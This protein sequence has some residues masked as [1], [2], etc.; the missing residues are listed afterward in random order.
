[1]LFLLFF[2]ATTA[3]TIVEL[4]DAMALMTLS[5]W[6]SQTRWIQWV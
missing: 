5:I 3:T 4:Y 2:L 1:M 6:M